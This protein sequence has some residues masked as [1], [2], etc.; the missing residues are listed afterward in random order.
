MSEYRDFSSLPPGEEAQFVPFEERSQVA[1]KKAWTVGAV[2]GGLVFLFALIVFF[3]HEKPVNQH[4]ED[5]M[6]DEQ[7]VQQDTIRTKKPAAAAEESSDDDAE[8]GAEGAD[9]EDG[10]AA[11]GGEA[12]ESGE[13]EAAEDGD[14]EKAEEAK[15]E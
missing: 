10:E 8:E 13:T 12:A 3:S 9:S 11:E 6:R 4:A 7:A 14:S 5:M 1:G 2:C 15:E